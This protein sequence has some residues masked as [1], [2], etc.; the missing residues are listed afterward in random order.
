M[1]DI[2]DLAAVVGANARRIRLASE[3]TLEEVSRE[4]RHVGLRWTT[5]KV[6]DLEAGRI[7]PTLPTLLSLS[8]ALSSATDQDVALSDL[9][10]HDGNIRINDELIMTGRAVAAALRGEPVERPGVDATGV[11]SDALRELSELPA[12]LRQGVRM[13]TVRQIHHD[14]TE[15]DAK[16]SRELGV[17]DLFMVFLSAKLWGET[18]TQ[19]RNELAG[20]D[21]N[22]QKRGRVTRELKAELSKFIAQ[23]KDLHNA[24]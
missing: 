23:Q 2:S 4:A 1:T 22:A 9:V 5:G 17:S 3:T 21:A 7:K 12:W 6:G 13:G 24:P 20:A 16:V 18:F 11:V 19:K 14:S 8:I 10:A 15:T